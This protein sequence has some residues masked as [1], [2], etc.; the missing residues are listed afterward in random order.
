MPKRRYKCWVLRSPTGELYRT[1]SISAFVKAHPDEFP[2]AQFATRQFYSCG[3]YGWDVVSRQTEDGELVLPPRHQ[4]R[5]FW[6]LLSPSGEV[7]GAANLTQ[8]LLDHPEDFPNP[9]AASCAFTQASGTTRTVCGWSVLPNPVSS[10][11]I[12]TWRKWRCYKLL[13][14][15]DCGRE[16]TG[17][18]KTIRCPECQAEADRRHNAEYRQRK[19]AGQARE[20]GSTAICE[21][22]G[23]A[24]TVESGLQR[25]CKACA[26][27]AI[28]E[29]RNQSSRE[30]NQAA[31]ADPAKRDGKNEARR[32]V[33]L[34]HTCTVCGKT[35][36][37]TGEPLYCSEDCRQKARKEY[38]TRYDQERREKRREDARARY[39]KLT[40]EEKEQRNAKARERYAKRKTTQK[41]AGE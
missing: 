14:C 38:Q 9:A 15:R 37:A 31:Y 29:Q 27:A 1:G 25:Y 26:P 23:A 2:N 13:T 30:W 39:A 40:P 16:Y 4:N 34:P 10:A 36:Y 22:C 41:N 32:A 11:K 33:P 20:I 17:H 21:R 6:T 18:I 28:K 24:Y 8:F 12:T 7:Y 5:T 3:V 35:F 19:R